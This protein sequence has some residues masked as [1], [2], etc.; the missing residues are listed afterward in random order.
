MPYRKIPFVSNQIYHVFNRGIASLPIFSLSRDYG[1]FLDLIN[2][3][4]FKNTPFSFSK[5]N[6]LSLEER[7]KILDE[8]KK[9][10]SLQVEIFAFCLMP[11]HFHFLIRQVVDKG[12][13]SFISNIQNGHA[14]YYNLKNNRYGSLFQSM[15]KAVRI[16]S[17]DQFLHVS[18]YIHLNPLTGFLVNKE[19]FLDYQWS[20]I[21]DYLSKDKER[22]FVN[23]QPILDMV[24]NK[25]KY[26][27]FILDQVDY[28][29]ELAQIK[30]LVLE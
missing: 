18:R 12:I 21:L 29:R 5:L 19:N 11:T 7:D 14:K 15:F 28:Q 6:N 10:N 20:S 17:D 27:E 23:S 3:Y 9:E 25:E 24:K 2:Y 1:R 16:E 13:S 8:L 26:K 22:I 4:R 30:H